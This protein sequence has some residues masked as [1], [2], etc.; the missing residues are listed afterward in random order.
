MKCPNCGAEIA[1]GSKTCEFCGTQI[2]YDMLREQE[3]LS[4]KGCPKCGSSNITFTRENQGEIRGRKAKKV[5]H[6]TVGYCKDCGYT[7]TPEME[8]PKKRRTFLWILGWIF[9]FPVPLTILML[10]KKEL[11]PAIKYGVIAAAWIIYLILVLVSRGNNKKQPST[12]S[13][14]PSVQSEIQQES[15]ISKQESSAAPAKQE[16]S[17][18]E[19]GKPEDSKPK[20]SKSEDDKPEAGRKEE[21][22]MPAESSAI[23]ET[24]EESKEESSEEIVEEE[25]SEEEASSEEES[26]EEESSEEE[27]SAEESSEEAETIDQALIRDDI[28]D[29]IDSYEAFIDEYCEFLESYDSSDLTMLAKYAEMLQKEVE[30]SQKFDA[31]ADEDLTEAEVLYYSEVSIRCSQKILAAASKQ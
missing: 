10:R 11:K 1:N 23:E 30:M 8:K 6:T 24:S 15:S 27:S 19:D 26:P 4:K 2:T 5:V 16:S 14:R 25:S 12:E 28:R 21:S 20:E 9:I 17:K 13:T 22:S 31:M 3:Q 29:A 7:W 18:P